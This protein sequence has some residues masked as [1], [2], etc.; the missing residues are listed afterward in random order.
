MYIK[1][2]L[3]NN[4]GISYYYSNKEIYASFNVK[5][6]LQ[7]DI[8]YIY[9]KNEKNFY[10]ILLIDSYKTSVFMNNLFRKIKENKNLDLL[11]ESDS[12]EEFEN[13]NN[14]KFVNLDKQ[15]IIKCKYYNKF[16]K[17]IPFEISNE[18]II[19]RKDLFNILK[20]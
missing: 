16:R 1:K 10:D 6:D 15:L 3:S 12:D 14:D 8:Y 18:S 9:L 7:T 2:N 11:E 4:Y 20:K 17:W 13:M 5:A 19:S